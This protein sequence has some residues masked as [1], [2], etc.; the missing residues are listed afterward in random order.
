[1]KKKVCM[2]VLTFMAVSIQSFAQGNLLITPKRVVFEGNSQQAELT[3]MNI[4]TDTATYSV[5]LRHYNMS[6]EGTLQLTEKT[7]TTQ[8]IADPFLRIF[9]RQ[10]TLAPGEAQ[11]VMMQYR[12]KPA[13]KDGEYRS[14]VWFRSEKDYEPL[15]KQQPALDS[16]QMSV[17]VTAILG[18][19]IPVIIRKGQVNVTTSLSGFKLE[20]ETDKR[21]TLQFTIH[22][23]GD[24][25]THGNVVVEY[26][27]DQG[28]PYQIGLVKGLSVFT[29][30]YQRKVSVKLN[31]VPGLKLMTGKLR[32]RYTSSD[33]AKY[34]VYAESLIS[35][36]EL[37][38]M[39]YA[40]VTDK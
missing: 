9:P 7:D 15:G 5:S 14:H 24:Y 32:V 19:T 17:S 26:V 37:G 8:K 23:E 3:L 22:R 36:D 34:S 27:P 1:M 28:K 31:Y 11:I 2:M 12:P 20:T 21:Q 39:N 13:M 38:W 30:I 16:T 10:V 29:N 6:E 25:S 33:E 18:I 35:R 4:G 40:I